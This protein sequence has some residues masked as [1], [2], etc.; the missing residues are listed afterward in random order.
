MK[1]LV[2]TVKM[3]AEEYPNLKLEIDKDT[4]RVRFN[5]K[6]TCGNKT[7]EIAEQD[8][9]LKVTILP[10]GINKITDIQGV[11]DIIDSIENKYLNN[12]IRKSET[13]K[14][15]ELL[16]VHPNVIKEFMQDGKLNKSDG[17]LGIL[18]WLEEEE[19]TMVKQFQ[20]TYGVL[21]YHVLKTYTVDMGIIYDLL[22]ISEDVECWDIEKDDLKNGYVLSY[23]VSAFSESGI[24][25]IKPINGGVVREY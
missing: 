2:D 21:V 17:K 15:L 4:V 3:V 16:N 10:E 1:Y 7:L 24:I 25:K 23:T 13:K 11:K 18:Y 19:E 14:R 9:R 20:E 22:Y 6:D 8:S 12:E 5:T